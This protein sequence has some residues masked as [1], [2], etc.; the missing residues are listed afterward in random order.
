MANTITTKTLELVSGTTYRIKNIVR[1]SGI[2]YLIRYT[3][4]NTTNVLFTFA[5]SYGITGIDSTA[6]YQIVE[7]DT[8]KLLSPVVKKINASGDYE[9]PITIS[10]RAQYSN[11]T[12]TFTGGTTGQVTIDA[13][14]DIY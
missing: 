4:G 3:K 13:C 14:D 7:A 12:V 5:Q 6:K 8:E 9:L 1:A 2:I 10:K 11:V